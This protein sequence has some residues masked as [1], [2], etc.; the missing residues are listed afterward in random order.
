M[1]LFDTQRNWDRFG[2]TDPYWAILTVP[3][4]EN[5]RWNVERFFASGREEIGELIAYLDRIAPGLPRGEALDFGCGVGRLTQPLG[6]LFA[7]AVGVDIAP[8][9]IERAR[10]FAAN[11]RCEFV[12]NS[13][14][15][16]RAF[17]DNRFDLVYSNITLQHIHPRYSTVYIRE[18]VRVLRPGGV[19]VF[20][21][22]SSAKSLRARFVTDMR[23]LYQIFRRLLNRPV[24]ELYT[25]PL[26]E[27]RSLIEQTGAEL[28]DIHPDLSAGTGVE[29][30]RY[31]VR[32]P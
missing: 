10:Q 25:V 27:V 30:F 28:V 6:E 5:N 32:K 23:I 7:H 20:Q 13:A 9:M 21:L 19:A 1:D 3:G 31:C 24:M 16:L 12:L 17:G 2:R 18:F 11:P 8:S 26:R 29:S 4:K 14:S 15:D 22:P